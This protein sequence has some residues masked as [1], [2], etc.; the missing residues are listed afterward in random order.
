MD[1]ISREEKQKIRSADRQWFWRNIP[2][3][4]RKGKEIHHNWDS[5]NYTCYLIEK[6]KHLKMHHREAK[7]KSNI[8]LIKI[9]T[10][11]ACKLQGCINRTNEKEVLK[12]EENCREI[13]KWIESIAREINVTGYLQIKTIG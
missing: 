2:E 1:G 11:Y 9:D 8:K 13:G 5:K 12:E 4:L 10:S 6:E 3:H 7:Q